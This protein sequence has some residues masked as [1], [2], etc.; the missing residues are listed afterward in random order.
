VWRINTSPVFVG[1]AVA[2]ATRSDECEGNATHL[3]RCTHSSMIRTDTTDQHG[4][5]AEAAY[6]VSVQSRIKALHGG[7][8]EHSVACPAAT[9]PRIREPRRAPPWRQG[10][11]CPVVPASGS[12][13][14]SAGP[15]C[16]APLG[17][18]QTTQ[19]TERPTLTCRSTV[20]PPTARA[21]ATS[22]RHRRKRTGGRNGDIGHSITRPP[23]LE[24]LRVQCHASATPGAAARRPC[25]R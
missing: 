17:A 14:R 22:F 12:Q 6:M 1:I 23:W 4:Q 15:R 21:A 9:R 2:R 3:P 13:R 10:A 8:Q 18:P 19:M 24:W 7:L 20:S 25:R 5:G 16:R 11:R